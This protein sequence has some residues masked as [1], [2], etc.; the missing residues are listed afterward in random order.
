MKGEVPYIEVDNR[1]EETKEK[2]SNV[3]RWM[4]AFDEYENGKLVFK[5]EIG[6]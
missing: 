1:G 3:K 2:L 5:K 6:F 4:E